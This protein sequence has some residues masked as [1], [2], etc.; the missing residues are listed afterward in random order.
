LALASLILGIVGLVTCFLIIPPL[1]AVIFGLVASRQIKHSSGRLTGAGLAL[2]GWIMGFVGLLL[3]GL[4]IAAAATGVF[5]GGETGVF[6]LESGDCANFDFN[7][8]SE[9]LIEVRTV[10]VIDCDEVHDAEVIQ[11]GDLNPNGD[12]DYPSNDELFEE[13]SAACGRR[14]LSRIFT[15]A[16]NERSWANDNGPF[17]CFELSQS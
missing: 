16:P 14:D 7:T 6:D 12:R 17:V 1:L 11:V 9:I 8:E 10:D 5:D 3:G 2:A 13:I 15:V 4:L